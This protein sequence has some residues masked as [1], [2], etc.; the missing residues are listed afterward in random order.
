MAPKAPK[1]AAAANKGR[2]GRGK[3]AGKGKSASKGGDSEGGDGGLITKLTEL[4][5]RSIEHESNIEI[6]RAQRAAKRKGVSSIKDNVRDTEGID[7]D[8]HLNMDDGIRIEPFNMRREMAEG[9]FDESGHYVQNK[10]QEKEVTDAW[11]DTID[12]AQ[13]RAKFKEAA[14]LKKATEKTK[15]TLSSLTKSIGKDAEEDDD[16]KKKEGAEGEEEAPPEP[17]KEEEEV[18]E[19]EEE[20]EITD[21]VATLEDLLTELKPL[22]TPAK[23][24]LRWRKAAA[25]IVQDSSGSAVPSSSSQAGEPLKMRSRIRKAKAE[26]AAAEKAAA[27]AKAA[28]KAGAGKRKTLNEWGNYE[29]KTEAESEETAAKF[30]KSILT[31]EDTNGTSGGGGE[32]A[33]AASGA[34]APTADAVAAESTTTGAAAELGDKSAAKPSNVPGDDSAAKR[35]ESVAASKVTNAAGVAAAKEK[36]DA[37]EKARK[38]AAEAAAADSKISK[39]VLHADLDKDNNP[40]FDAVVNLN[41]DD[42]KLKEDEEF[43]EEADVRDPDPVDASKTRKRKAEANDFEKDRRAKI[44]RLTDLC[45]RLLERGVLVYDST[46]EQLSIEVRERRGEKILGDD[47]DGAAAEEAKGT[48]AAVSENAEEGGSSASNAGEGS[49]AAPSEKITAPEVLY[50]NK[51][52]QPA[53]ES[54]EGSEGGNSLM[55]LLQES[56]EGN[57]AGASEAV[58]QGQPLLWQYRWTAKPSEVHG[59]FD[60]TTLQGWVDVSCFAEERPAEVR[61]CDANNEPT[62][63]CWHRWDKIDFQLY[64]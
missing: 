12:K 36:A 20:Q 48:A 55:S 7:E 62:E 25:P 38:E 8:C 46:K 22:E 26:A 10:D 44:E 17:A 56:Q 14:A 24:L 57:A 9:H 37:Q 21:I 5:D 40:E 49:A 23:A 45:D 51:R 64:I 19:A 28:A 47:Q 60:S 35:I 42:Q 30:R 50:T 63:T 1:D 43:L 27:A 41:A 58:S 18:D 2:G 11:L 31:E 16:E 15:K 13:R 29:A 34:E 33:A 6:L 3:A 54:K 52:C 53:A 32:E 59:P 4:D 61:Q 39:L